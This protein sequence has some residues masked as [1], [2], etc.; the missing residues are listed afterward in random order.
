MATESPFDSR[1]YRLDPGGP[2]ATGYGP[3]KVIHAT[4]LTASDERMHVMD[5]RATCW[6]RPWNEVVNGALR[7]THK[8][9]TDAE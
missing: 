5:D 3:M 7:I 9:N 1:E 8:R 2:F 6:C 4:P